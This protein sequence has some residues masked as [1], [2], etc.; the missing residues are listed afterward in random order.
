MRHFLAIIVLCLCSC[1]LFA[2]DPEN[3]LVINIEGKANGRVEIEL[4]PEIAPQHVAR[5]KRLAREGY[6]ENIAF[7]RVLENFMAQTGDVKFGRKDTFVPRYAG[8]GSSVYPDLPAEFSDIPFTRGIVGMA[9]STE[10]NSANSQFFIMYGR[11]DYLDKKYTVFGRVIN[12]MEVV[13]DIRK[14]NRA[15]N[16]AVARPDFMTRVFIKAD[17]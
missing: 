11:A 10:P 1:P 5:I 9:R 16:G 13:D 4:L 15:A 12:G 17:E 8:L 3:I 2:A 7:H 6:Y 14:G